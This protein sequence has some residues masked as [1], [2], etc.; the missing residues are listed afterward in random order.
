MPNA[1]ENILSLEGEE[2]SFD[3]VA[4][5]TDALEEEKQNAQD[6]YQHFQN[7]IDEEK[8][9]LR[10]PNIGQHA[11][12]GYDKSDIINLNAQKREDQPIR[13]RIRV[14]QKYYNT[15]ELYRGHLHFKAGGDRY[16]M[17]SPELATHTWDVGGRSIVF[18]NVDDE[19]Y[20]Y[21]R[22]S[23]NYPGENKKVDY[24]R[25]IT[26]NNRQ[27]EIVDIVLD[28]R[29]AAILDSKAYSE[30]TDNYLRNALKRNKNRYG[31][32]SIIQTIQKKQD[33]IMTEEPTQSLIVQGCA[34]SGKTMVMLHRIRYLLYNKKIQ[35]D[36]YALLIPSTSFK[37][38]IRDISSKFS[39][40]SANTYSYH[41]YYQSFLKQ[42]K[43]NATAI[44]ANELVFAPKYLARVYSRQFM[45]ECYGELLNTIVTQT[46][47]LCECC[48]HMVADWD[49]AELQ[50]IKEE[51]E[52]A[53]KH[54]VS[55]IQNIT[56]KIKEQLKSPLQEYADIPD[57]LDSLTV[58]LS[59]HKAFLET[60]QRAIQDFVIAEDDVRIQTDARLCRYNEEIAAE[61][62]RLKRASR[63]T[64]VSYQQKLN[65][66]VEQRDRYYRE[67]IDRV[68]EEEKQFRA[69]EAEKLGSRFDETTLSELESIMEGSKSIFDLAKQTIELAQDK[70][71][72]HDSMFQE[73]FAAE[74]SALNDL[75][76][77][78]GDF[79]SRTHEWMSA[80]SSDVVTIMQY[81]HVGSE[82]YAQFLKHIQGAADNKTGISEKKFKEK[83]RIFVPRKEHELQSYLNVLMMAIIR[84]KIKAEF[85]IKIC[86]H[87]KHYWYLSLYSHYLTHGSAAKQNMYLFIDE[88]QD[89]SP[90]EIELIRK[91]N[92]GIASDGI[93]VAPVLNIFGDVN[94]TITTHGIR[95]WNQIDCT[96]KKLLLDENFRNTNQIID[97][98]NSALPFKMQKIGIDMDD[99]DQFH[100]LE[101][102]LYLDAIPVESTFIV[103][104]EYAAEDLRLTTAHL[105]QRNWNIY[106]VKAAKGMEFRE[107]FVID[108][109]M[110]D[111][112]R[113]I[114]YTRA[115][116][117]LTIINAVPRL[118]DRN[119]SLVIQ[120]V[121]D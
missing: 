35:G 106:T 93:P 110:C 34:G 17:E 36:E 87:Y 60:K 101:E 11:R 21:E 7:L 67:L 76:S 46:D 79:I 29:N 9:N 40:S 81:V 44:E 111:N 121:E 26:M 97:Y 55:E 82:L 18:I 6:N 30:I 103:K 78:S 117:K 38:Y 95:N 50:K 115:L 45:Q 65:Q 14:L 15:D 24:S 25:N 89:L 71:H 56:S 120:G 69:A 102:A 12:G 10:Y 114:A 104:D 37:E 31:M 4:F 54:A 75:I 51:I 96:G 77:A 85:G 48:D 59:E 1:H 33:E 113:Y 27:V 118:A 57:C 41:R 90:S 66:L 100:S 19:A 3:D 68:T 72:N 116:A 83:H 63:F 99:V 28:R 73:Q 22:R 88:A 84:K 53:Q 108:Q 98:C 107:V 13:E 91:V 86:N 80:L 105:E 92:T 20:S 16:F 112:E 2:M 74:L 23:W 58:L 5:E 43:K 52:T 42:P 39:I 61:E 32:E 62:I 119:K 64:A 47:A 8:A 49:E 94:Q 70:L 109:D